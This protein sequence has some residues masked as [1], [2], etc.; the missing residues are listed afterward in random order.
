M[1]SVPIITDVK[2]ARMVV[3][4]SD[5]QAELGVVK[6]RLIMTMLT[7]LTVLVLGVIGWLGYNNWYAS[8]K[9]VQ[10]T[11]GG[12]LREIGRAIDMWAED[13][14]DAYPT[15]DEI[16]SSNVISDPSKLICPEMKSSS[17][18]VSYGYNGWLGSGGHARKDFMDPDSLP[19][20]A[21]ATSKT[22]G[23]MS[24]VAIRRHRG[25]FQ[26]FDLKEHVGEGFNVVFAGGAVVWMKATQTLTFNQ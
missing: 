18:T 16:W 20:V 1:A 2:P 10:I 11:C 17:N 24:D 5:E 21:D 13:H 19:L 12:N 6:Y 4:S 3:R 25:T 15:A 14:E 9:K 23:S 22:L 26:D 8:Q 7:I